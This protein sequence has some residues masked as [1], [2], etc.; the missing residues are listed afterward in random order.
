MSLSLTVSR[1]K[2]KFTAQA[3]EGSPPTSAHCSLDPPARS[4]DTSSPLD[5]LFLRPGPPSGFPWKTTPS[6]GLSPSGWGTIPRG[7]LSRVYL[8]HPPSP[9]RGPC[10]CS[11]STQHRAWHRAEPLLVGNLPGV[12]TAGPAQRLDRETTRGLRGGPDRAL[13]DTDHI[14]LFCAVSLPS[15]GPGVV[16]AQ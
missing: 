14:L 10:L 13:V 9:G 12:S 6:S 2:S 11:L 16:G 8:P 5:P 7:S 15:A 1:I 4:L 3:L